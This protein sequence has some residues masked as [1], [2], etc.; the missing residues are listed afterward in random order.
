MGEWEGLRKGESGNGGKR[1]SGNGSMGEWESRGMGDSE[2]ERV[3]EWEHGG[4]NNSLHKSS[5]CHSLFP[6]LTLSPIPQ[7]LTKESPFSLI[8]AH[9][10]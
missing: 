3:G 7:L 8:E 9:T 10:L 6:P 2:K 4:L 5:G 1:E